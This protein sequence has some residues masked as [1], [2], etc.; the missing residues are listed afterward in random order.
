MFAI[1][2]GIGMVLVG[3][4]SFDVHPGRYTDDKNKGQSYRIS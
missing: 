4:I 1:L 2:A 3:A